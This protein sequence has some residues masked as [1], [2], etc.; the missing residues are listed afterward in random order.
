MIDGEILDSYANEIV[1]KKCGAVYELIDCFDAIRND[2]DIRPVMMLRTEF[3]ERDKDITSKVDEII[4][5]IRKE[6]MKE[7]QKGMKK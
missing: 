7:I 3:L 5:K 1:C 2:I 6:I 4:Y